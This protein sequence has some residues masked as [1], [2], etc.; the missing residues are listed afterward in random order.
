[1]S[2]SEQKIG[3]IPRLW[4]QGN[5]GPQDWALV[6]TNQRTIL[7]LEKSSKAGLGGALGGAIGAAIAA[8][9]SNKRQTFDYAN[10]DPQTLASDNHN[11]TITHEALL[12]IKMHKKRIGNAYELEI[13]YQNEERKTKTFKGALLPPNIVVQQRKEQGTD[14][15]QIFLDYARNAVNVFQNALSPAR[16]ASLMPAM[17]F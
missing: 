12:Q 13:E 15:G 16:L 8:A 7:V 5:W 9:A 4:V 11:K 14:K 3:L 2:T 6:V 17:P 10:M 1:L